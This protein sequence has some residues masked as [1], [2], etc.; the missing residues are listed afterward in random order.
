M[1]RCLLIILFRLKDSGVI[2]VKFT[3]IATLLSFGAVSWEYP[4]KYHIVRELVIKYIRSMLFKWDNKPCKSVSGPVIWLCIQEMPCRTF[5]PDT[6]V[7]LSF[8]VL[9]R[10]GGTL[11]I[12]YDI[13]NTD[14][15]PWGKHNNPIII[16]KA[17]ASVSEWLLITCVFAF[18]IYLRNFR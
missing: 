10:F 16:I 5:I 4:V 13:I 3:L 6:T 14:Q 11:N 8:K 17:L 12:V 15:W 9:G 18:L 2:D 7:V 1:K